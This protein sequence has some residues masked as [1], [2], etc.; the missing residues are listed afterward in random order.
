MSDEWPKPWDQITQ[1]KGIANWMEYDGA[2]RGYNGTLY[3][4]ADA[5][6]EGDNGDEWLPI[7]VYLQRGGDV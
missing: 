3:I 4:N 1:T 6:H 7:G 5:G 2:L